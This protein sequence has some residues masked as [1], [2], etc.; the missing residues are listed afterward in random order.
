MKISFSISLSGLNSSAD[1]EK[2][3][4]AEIC[5]FH[6]IFLINNSKYLLYV[7][8]CKSVKKY[9]GEKRNLYTND[10]DL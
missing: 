4:Y 6:E 9:K 1:R 8:P 10:L 5:S 7:I 2:S 3:G